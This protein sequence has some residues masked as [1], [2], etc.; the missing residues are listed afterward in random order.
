MET[1][2][3]TLRETVDRGKSLIPFYSYSQNWNNFTLYLH[4][5]NEFEIIYVEKGSIIY[6]IDTVSTK[7]SEG[8]AIII[9]SGQLHSAHTINGEGS[10]HHALL[11]DL[12]FLNSAINDLCQNNYIDPLLNGD[13]RF[14][15]II[16]E[17]YIWGRKVIEEVKEILGIC[18]LK[19]F[20][21]E[22]GIK[23]SLYKIVSIIARE[24]KL[25]VNKMSSASSL[26]YKISII[27]NTINYI[28]NKYT[29]K[30]YIEDLAKEANMNPQ[31]FCRFFKANTG[32][33]IVDFINQY[34]IEQ[35]TKL[36]KTGYKKISDI[37][38]EVGFD[39]FSYFIKKFKEYENMTP[40][41]YKKQLLNEI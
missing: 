20:G 5:H 11:F 41:Q 39:N 24:N 10:L 17:N 38:L 36:L 6:T 7:V 32:K 2:R 3:N 9:N 34:R 18:S 35:A 25:I 4:W 40:N 23:A 12:N 30:M 13:F 26:N 28:Q 21:W 1:E 22:I 14:P 29:E 33:T 31:Y 16:D 27:K 15:L 8:Q 19:Q 37:Y